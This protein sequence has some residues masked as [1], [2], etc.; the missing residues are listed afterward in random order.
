MDERDPFLALCDLASRERWCWKMYCTTC[1]HAYFRHAFKELIA[2]KHPDT[3]VWIVRKGNHHA[4]NTLGPMP[5][6][7]GWPIHEQRA[8]ARVLVQTDTRLI[9]EICR[10]PDWLGYLGLA[11]AYTEDAEWKDKT[12]TPV[13]VRQL[14]TLIGSDI[15]CSAFLAELPRTQGRHLRWGDL[16]TV[17]SGI[18]HSQMKK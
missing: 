17:E 10:F 2:G 4:L 18:L 15:H 6:L 14:I 9:H 5:L 12:I 13:I 1:G 11:L 16:E 7:G 3:N 8:L